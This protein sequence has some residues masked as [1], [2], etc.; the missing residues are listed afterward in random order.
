MQAFEHTAARQLAL[1]TREQLRE[2]GFTERQITSLI[3]R[4]FLRRMRVGVYAI[5]G[6]PPSWE[7]TALA[8]VLATG[9]V[10]VA[11]HASAARLWTF[12]HRPDDALELTI[13]Y[14]HAAELR[15]VGVHRSRVL[16][17]TDVA[18]R[19]GVPCTSFERTL[20]DCTTRLSK[21]QLGRVLDDGLRRGVASLARLKDCAE[22][23]ESGPGRHMSVVR[24]LLAERG[25]DFH[26]GGSASERDVL[27][28]I[29][30]AG[31]PLPVQQFAVRVG[32]REYSLDYAYP[33]PM[34]LVEYYGLRVHSGPSAVAY[35]SERLTALV[36]MGWMPLIFTDA[37]PDGVIVERV[38]AALVNRAP[39]LSSAAG[40]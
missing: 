28:V 16:D 36:A 11:S 32:G 3:R 6:A 1:I 13:P 21:F 8:A 12:A 24:A 17:P 34:I 7:Q 20:C 27:D 26:P 14:G 29:R 18:S 2:S 40:D 39:M 22:R 19:N 15:G 5:A 33:A 37:T 25:V 10:A 31:L 35:D 38:S 9:D 23:I 4:R 30:R